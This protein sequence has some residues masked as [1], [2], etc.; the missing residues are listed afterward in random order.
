MAANPTFRNNAAHIIYI[1]M[2]NF[3]EADEMR[4]LQEN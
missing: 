4:Y 1:F 2:G 3:S